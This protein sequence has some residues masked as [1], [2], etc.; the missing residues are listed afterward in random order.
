MTKRELTQYLNSRSR[1]Q[2][3]AEIGEIFWKFDTVKDYY[4]TRLEPD[5]SKN[6]CDKYK[7]V[8]HDEFFPE[9]GDGRA[10]LSIAR[11]AVNDFKKVSTSK[12]ARADLMLYYVEIGVEYT[13]TY[14]DINEA[15]YDS[16][17]RMYASTANYI[18]EHEMHD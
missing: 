8:I 10:R 6:V 14:G 13:V 2:L 9:K 15:F 17:E 18:V 11:K 16:M 7:S 4:Q 1:D 5:G 12:S 3:I